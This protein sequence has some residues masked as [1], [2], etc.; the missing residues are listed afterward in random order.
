MIEKNKNITG[1]LLIE[2][3][4]IFPGG[5]GVKWQKARDELQ[6]SFNWG[7]WKRLMDGAQSYGGRQV[8]QDKDFGFSRI[9]GKV[10]YRAY[11]SNEFGQRQSK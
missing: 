10:H 5:I 9:N 1:R 4:D 2:T 7:K 3:D 6:K 11:A 8:W